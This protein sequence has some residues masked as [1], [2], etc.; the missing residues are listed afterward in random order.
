LLLLVVTTVVAVVT[1]L[2]LVMQSTQRDLADK[3]DSYG[4]NIVV[5]PRSSQLPLVYGGVQLG[6]VTYAVEPLTM[7]QVALIRTIE[8]KQNLNRVSPNLLQ[9]EEVGGVRMTAVGVVWDQE[10]GLK[11]WWHITGRPPT[12]DHDVLLG[13]KAGALTGKAAGDSLVLR[14]ESFRVAGVLEPTGTQEDDALFL[15]LATAQ[16]LWNRPGQVSF[17]EVSAWCA[18]CPIENISA[19]ISGLLPGAQVSA[20]RKAVESRQ[21]L[22]GQLRLFSLALSLFLVLAGFLIVL[23]STLAGV[24]ERKNEIGVFRALGY[25]RSH[26]LK[27][28]LL[29]NLALAVVAGTVGV[30]LAAVLAGPSAV[31]LAG[32]ARPT[33]AGISALGLAFAAAVLA[34]VAASV[35]PAWQAAKL[36][37]MLALRRV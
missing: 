24:R 13:S 32:V 12:G 6:G 25:R 17:V 1:T 27:I 19:Q 5:V 34:V 22:I 33:A 11:K 35:Y 2:Y 20:L 7:Q 21:L 30:G 16:R 28:V 3:V 10:L 23:S 9:L 36:S 15:D 4:A 8:N 26:V 18:T 37:P 31:L 14:G 29:E